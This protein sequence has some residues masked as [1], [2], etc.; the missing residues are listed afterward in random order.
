MKFRKSFIP[1]SNDPNFDKIIKTKNITLHNLWNGGK[2]E[3]RSKPIESIVK[4]SYLKRTQELASN[5]Q[6]DF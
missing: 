1:I 6:L 2:T 4:N 5:M 3:K